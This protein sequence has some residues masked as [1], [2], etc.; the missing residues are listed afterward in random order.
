MEN[1][2][3]IQNVVQV[4][5][6]FSETVMTNAVLT[7]NGGKLIL[8]QKRRFSNRF[9]ETIMTNGVLRATIP[10]NLISNFYLKIRFR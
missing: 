10:K 2:F 1:V 8:H 7:E 4:S 6:R 9:S 5:N 3:S